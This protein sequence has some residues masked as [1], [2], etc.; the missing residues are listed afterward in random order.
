MPRN[1]LSKELEKV[2]REKGLLGGPPVRKPSAACDPAPPSDTP[3]D[4]FLSATFFAPVR[5]ESEM[6]NREHWAARKKRFDRQAA[7]VSEAMEPARGFVEAVANWMNSRQSSGVVRI[8]LTRIGKRRLDSDNCAGGFKACRDEI[9][10]QIGTDDGS[11]LFV[12]EYAQQVGDE[13]GIRI[14]IST[15]AV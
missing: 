3:P 14:D 4:Y 6:N 10:R 2:A 11:D 8:V 5:I 1:K 12:W 15:E 13:Y 7:A 9:A